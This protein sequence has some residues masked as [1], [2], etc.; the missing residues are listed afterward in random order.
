M[1]EHQNAAEYIRASCLSESVTCKPVPCNNPQPYTDLKVTYVGTPLVDVNGNATITWNNHLAWAT[2]LKVLQAYDSSTGGINEGT[3]KTVLF[4]EAPS[5]VSTFFGTSG[6]TP[7]GAF[8]SSSIGYCGQVRFLGGH[9]RAR[10][11]TTN[12]NQGGRLYYI[13]NPQ[14]ASLLSKYISQ[15]GTVSSVSI[16]GAALPLVVNNPNISCLHSMSNGDFCGSIL[17]HTTEFEDVD[18][19]LSSSSATGALTGISVLSAAVDMSN[20]DRYIPNEVGTTTHLGYTNALVYVPAETI[21][22]GLSSKL[23]FELTMHYHINVKNSSNTT[24]QAIGFSTTAGTSLTQAS[25]ANPMGAAAINSA[26]ATIK[27][28]R[29]D[30]PSLAIKPPTGG[31]GF[32]SLLGDVI[33]TVWNV[34]PTIASMIPGPVGI[35]G[36]A[37]TLGTELMGGFFSNNSRPRAQQRLTNGPMGNRYP[38]QYQEYV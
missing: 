32:G 11:M 6:L 23:V 28:A 22:T 30:R 17:P 5:G 13:H 14:N 7:S 20:T 26:L 2:D 36:K 33:R 38:T 35:A 15:A 37:I 24:G 3:I 16:V 1:T 8:D 10:S 29:I 9:F 31:S 25:A 19:D 34:A 12:L 4:G 18:T 21:G 27:Q